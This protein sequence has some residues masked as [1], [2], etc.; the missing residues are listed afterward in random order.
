VFLILPD[1]EEGLIELLP[2]LGANQCTR[3]ESW[4]AMAATLREEARSARSKSWSLFAVPPPDDERLA[5]ISE[6]VGEQLSQEGQVVLDLQVKMVTVA[7]LQAVAAGM[8]LSMGLVAVLRLKGSDPPPPLEEA[9]DRELMAAIVSLGGTV[10]TGQ[11]AAQLE[12]R[13]VPLRKRLQVLVR[14]GRLKQKG[15]KGGTRYSLPG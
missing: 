2:V 14:F 12:R 11:L 5:M 3:P 9:S 4:S 8:G 13:R 6:A 10:S 15:M 1:N 7:E